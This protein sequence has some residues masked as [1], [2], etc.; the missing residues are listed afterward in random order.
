MK[1]TIYKIVPSFF[2]RHY[3][4]PIQIE[5]M[6][7]GTEQDPL[8]IDKSN[9]QDFSNVLLIKNN[10]HFIH[11]RNLNGMGFIFEKSKNIVLRNCV[12]QWIN[13]Q[14]CS[15]IILTNCTLNWIYTSSC[16]YIFIKNNQFLKLCSIFDKC[17]DLTIEGSNFEDRVEFRNFH[18]NYIKNCYLGQIYNDLTSNNV[19]ENCDIYET[20]MIKLLEIKLGIKDSDT[21]ILLIVIPILILLMIWM[22]RRGIFNDIPYILF[23]FV[24]LIIIITLLIFY[25]QRELLKNKNRPPNIIK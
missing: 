18:N 14:F 9:F 11:I 10:D 6:G 13:M 15:N 23:A 19:F 25:R 1:I 24:F 7:E 5:C 2:I 3:Y 17:Q 4:K 12:L 16:S 8:L 20:D 22:F 21:W